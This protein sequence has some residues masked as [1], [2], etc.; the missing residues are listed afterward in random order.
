V[1][2]V[3]AAS[4]HLGIDPSRI[5]LIGSS[6]GGHLALLAACR[7]NQA[8]HAGSPLRWGGQDAVDEDIDASVSCVA[9]LWPPV[10]TSTRYDWLLECLENASNEERENYESLRRGMEAYFGD[11]ETMAVASV[12]RIIREGEATHLPP[13]WV[14]YPELDQNVPFFIVQDLEKTW[15]EAGGQVEV[16]VYP[17]QSHAFGHRAGDA[18]DE[19]VGDLASFLATHL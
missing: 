13:V 9:A 8:E 17:G 14:C 1:R 4:E 12:P 18:T 19:F 3:R 6:S 15:R 7:P 10:D 5:A 2:W 16:R 11:R